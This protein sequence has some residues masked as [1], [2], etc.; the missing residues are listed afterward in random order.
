MITEELNAV[1]SMTAENRFTRDAFEELLEKF[2][3]R[4]TTEEKFNLSQANVALQGKVQFPHDGFLTED[5]IMEEKFQYSRLLKLPDKVIKYSEIVVNFELLI[6][7][8]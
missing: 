2:I 6:A 4:N 8:K 1:T 5:E 3:K 7:A